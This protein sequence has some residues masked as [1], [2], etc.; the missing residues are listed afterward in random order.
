MQPVELF[1][2]GE[3]RFR[4]H[5]GE[6]PVAHGEKRLF[7]LVRRFVRLAGHV[8]LRIAALLQDK[9]RR[10]FAAQPRAVLAAAGKPFVVARVV[11][12]DLA[13]HTLPAV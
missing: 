8:P 12:A 5:D 3:R 11:G 4:L 2:E 10:R 6:Q 9:L 7:Q 1:V 13:E